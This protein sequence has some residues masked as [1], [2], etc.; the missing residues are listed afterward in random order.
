[1]WPSEVVNTPEKT[2]PKAHY[3]N[4]LV[5]EESEGQQRGDLFMDWP[6]ARHAGHPSLEG[7]TGTG[8]AVLPCGMQGVSEAVLCC[9]PCGVIR[10]DGKVVE[11]VQEPDTPRQL[12]GVGPE[13]QGDVAS[14]HRYR[15]AVH[16]HQTKLVTGMHNH[17]VACTQQNDMVS[18]P[19]EQQRPPKVDASQVSSLEQCAFKAVLLGLT[20][21]RTAFFFRWRSV[22][23]KYCSVGRDPE[24]SPP[25]TRAN[26]PRSGVGRPAR[27]VPPGNVAR[28]PLPVGSGS[29]AFLQ[30]VQPS[31]AIHIMQ[32]GE[33][34]SAN[35][36]QVCETFRVEGSKISVGLNIQVA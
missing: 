30:Q 22:T 17:P 6:E 3:S 15:A 26:E 21:G 20:Q 32:V 19:A 27:E 18:E 12:I 10:D 8:R 31:A 2:S 33:G 4:F 23:V 5:K 7:M 13:G 29:C 9:E 35:T 11:G 34:A 36:F 28:A 25:S 16:Q 1:M 24:A 14:T